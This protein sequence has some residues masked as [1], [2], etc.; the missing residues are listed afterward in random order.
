MI[1]PAAQ[2]TIRFGVAMAPER[3]NSALGLVRAVDRAPY[4][5]KRQGRN[6]VVLFHGPTLEPELA[7]V[8]TVNNVPVQGH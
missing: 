1:T 7:A 3:A 2:V 6:R 5:A 4:T 8:S